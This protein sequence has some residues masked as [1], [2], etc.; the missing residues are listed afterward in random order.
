M[1]LTRRLL[2]ARC[3]CFSR[4]LSG[5]TSFLKP[6]CSRASH[7]PSYSSKAIAMASNRFCGQ[8]LFFRFF[9][10]SLAL[11]LDTRSPLSL[12]S[13]RKPT[14]IGANLCDPMFRGDYGG[15]SYHAPDLPAVLSRAQAAGVANVVVT[16]GS[17][18]ESEEARELVCSSSSYSSS[19][20]SQVELFYSVGVHPTRAGQLVFKKEG[21]G[22]KGEGAEA[23]LDTDAVGRLRALLQKGTITTT[24][25]AAAGSDSPKRLLVALGETGLDY[26][27]LQF[28]DVESQRLAFEAQLDLASEF[29]GQLPLF[30]HLRGAGDDFIDLLSKPRFLRNSPSSSSPITLR[31]VVHSFDGGV[32]LMRRLLNLENRDLFIGFNGCSLREE[33]GLEAARECP[34]DRILL[35][36]DAPWCDLR[37]T[38]ASANQD[39]FKLKEFDAARGVVWKDKKKLSGGGESGGDFLVKGRN[40]PC[41]IAAVAAAMAAAR[42]CEVEEVARAAWENSE[43]LC[44]GGGGGG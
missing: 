5:S 37:P 21:G 2:L 25:A 39:K 4:H 12:S 1:L 26:A 3:S 41:R 9:F 20:S 40:E 34:L 8:F 23:T 29:G 42:G 36:T 35:E 6:T 17:L 28:S 13:L 24:A 44:F 11:D 43:R 10:L 19:T 27:R 16:A 15:K 18:S 22:E 7:S 38:H 14:D 31:G 30:L 33:S 32:E